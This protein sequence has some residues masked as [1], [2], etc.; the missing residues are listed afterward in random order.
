M[1]TKS[2]F[3]NAAQIK[4]ALRK[5]SVTVAFALRLMAVPLTK[6]VSLERHV[7]LLEIIG[8][9]VKMYAPFATSAARMPCVD[10]LVTWH[11]VHVL[12]VHKE[13]NNMLQY[14]CFD[15][16]ISILGFYGSPNDERVGC[17]KKQCEDNKDCPGERKCENFVCVEP[18]ESKHILKTS[19][20]KL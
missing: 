17:Q 8:R 14:R 11:N 6:I 12:K 7:D 3:Q 15:N 9:N 18:Q 19:I 5:A 2:A 16:L 4:I 10:L 1:P 13:F 20:T